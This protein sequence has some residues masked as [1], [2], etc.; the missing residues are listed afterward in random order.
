M[1]TL[2]EII[3]PNYILLNQHKHSFSGRLSIVRLFEDLFSNDQLPGDC[4]ISPTSSSSCDKV[5]YG[6]YNQTIRV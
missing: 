6:S 4:Y 1:N 5:V 2:L 3:H